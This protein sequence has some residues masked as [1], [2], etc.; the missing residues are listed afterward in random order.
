MEPFVAPIDGFHESTAP[1]DWLEG[2]MK[3]YVGDGVG[4]DFYREIARFLD[5]RHP[6][7]GARRAGRH[8][9]VGVRR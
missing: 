2:L 5:A 3:A 9:P 4:A 6:G 1:A 7:A 8:R